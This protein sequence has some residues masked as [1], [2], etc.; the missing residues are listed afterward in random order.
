M[1][2]FKSSVLCALFFST[3]LSA[4]EIGC[5]VVVIV[6]VADIVGKSF[7]EIDPTTP[8]EESYRNIPFSPEVGPYSCPRTHQALFNEVGRVLEQRGEE[9]LVEF[10]NFFWRKPS[11]EC[12]SSGWLLARN[13]VPLEMLQNAGINNAIPEPIRFNK[14][15][16]TN[17]VLTLTMPWNHNE[18][19]M[20]FSAGTRFV[21]VSRL[22]TDLTYGMCFIDPQGKKIV[23]ARVDRDSALVNYPQDEESC[24][25]LFIEIL[26]RWAHL[27]PNKIP[28]VFGGCS[29]V[30]TC[31]PEE[32]ELVNQKRGQDDLQIWRRP[33]AAIP[34]CGLRLLR[35]S[36]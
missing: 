1:N 5:A 25:A 33:H 18:T 4:Q 19:G 31:K 11:G 20:T 6:P 14:P 23:Q 27:S 21:R 22:D 36:I 29:V 3:F 17:Q 12:T 35:S 26:K 13:V 32:F 34:H 28:Y 15:Y 7:A 24:R 9:L 16:V 10:T 2:I 8:V 30:Y